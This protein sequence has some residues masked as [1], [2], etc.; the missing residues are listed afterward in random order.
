MSGSIKITRSCI[1]PP[2]KDS[3]DDYNA[4]WVELQ[5]GS[6]ADLSN[7]VVEHYINPDTQEQDW[8]AY[9]R[10]GVSERFSPGQRIRIHSG[11]GEARYE[12][13]VHHRYVAGPGE[14]GQWRLNN[15]GDTIRV[16]DPSH[17]ELD[18][19]AFNG[20]EGYCAQGSNSDP[21]PQRKPPTQYA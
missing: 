9:Y 13:G 4:E 16:L 15:T 19:K 17:N 14:K 11:A 5:V 18:R 3:R 20:N 21:G 1:N 8:S 7:H 10:F 2:G 12:D 6:G